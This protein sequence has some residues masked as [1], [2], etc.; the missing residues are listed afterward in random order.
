MIVTSKVALRI[1]LVVL[2]ALLLQNA[3][4]SLIEVFGVSFWILPAVVAIF[5]MLGGS[6]IGATV[7]FAIGFL[8]DGLTDGPLGTACLV[9]MGIGYA[10][11]LY[12]ERRD[13]PPVLAAAIIAGAATFIANVA[14]GLFTTL[15]G[16]DGYLSAAALPDLLVQSVYA[17]VLAAP[18]FILIRRI[19]RPALV[20][21]HTGRQGRPAVLEPCRPESADHENRTRIHQAQ[22]PQGN[23]PARGHYRRPGAGAFRR[24]VLSPLVATGGDRRQV[25][26]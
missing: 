26:G 25:P 3:F 10:T 14:L 11:G 9:F 12:R 2:V 6:M 18:L 24:A 23:G 5:G 17:F 22:A 13:Q 1:A 19:L 16:F 21:E 4:F 7:G 15:L 8:A 20:H